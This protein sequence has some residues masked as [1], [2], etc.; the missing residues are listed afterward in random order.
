LR[1]RSSKQLSE[2]SRVDLNSNFTRDTS[3]KSEYDETGRFVDEPIRYISWDAQPSWTYLLS[4]VDE[5]KIGGSYRENTYDS[6]EKT[7]Y[8]YFGG[9]L[10]Y[11]HR[12]SEIDRATATLSYFRYI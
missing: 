10:D 9:A 12:L 5:I 2:R 6:S 8:Q 1:L 7:D 4:P 11:S 3:L